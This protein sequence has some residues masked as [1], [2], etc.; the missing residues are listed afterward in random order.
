MYG[1]RDL[2]TLHARFRSSSNAGGRQTRRGRE[3]EGQ[4]GQ[5]DESGRMIA[6][7]RADYMLRRQRPS[8]MVHALSVQSCFANQSPNGSLCA[9]CVWRRRHSAVASS[10][11]PAPTE[12]PGAGRKTDS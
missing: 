4:R 6:G 2:S 10:A 12:G 9:G 7:K 3:R 1:D 11:V 5:W 8:G